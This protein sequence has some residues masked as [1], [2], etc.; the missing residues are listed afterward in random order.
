MGE[1]G[2]VVH[3]VVAV[4]HLVVGSSSQAGK[5]S[6][7]SPGQVVATVVLHRQPAVDEVED[8]LAQRVAAHHP[9]A[10]QSQQQQRQQLSRAGVLRRQSEEDAVLVVRHVDVT[11][12]PR[13][14]EDTQTE[15]K[16]FS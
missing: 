7:Q 1:V 4:V 8:G 11:E 5:Q 15:A 16:T 12:E 3:T 13:N 14:P 10:D 2:G 6:V 9:G